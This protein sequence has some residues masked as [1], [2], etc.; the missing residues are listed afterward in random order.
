MMLEATD[1]ISNR[2][3]VGIDPAG[4]HGA[5][6]VI[7]E[8]QPDGSMR[9]IEVVYCEHGPVAGTPALAARDPGHPER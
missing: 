1:P 6:M 5:C 9:V 7:L 4:A 8:E 2:I 3:F